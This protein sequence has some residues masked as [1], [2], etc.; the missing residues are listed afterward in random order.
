[1]TDQEKAERIIHEDDHIAVY[2]T[3]EK[4]AG[5]AYHCYD[6]VDKETDKII[7]SVK[8]QN[9]PIQ[10]N[11]VNGNTNEALLAIVA[12]RLQCFQQGPYPSW[13]N[14]VALNAAQISKDIL[15]ARTAERKARG[16]EGQTKA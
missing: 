10:E 11:G 7:D 4:G 15:E 12:H 1:M 2:V 9:G 13:Y 3:D 8:F 14:K 5:G 6:V 16:V